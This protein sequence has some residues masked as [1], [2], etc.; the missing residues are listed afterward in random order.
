MSRKKYLI[1][2]ILIFIIFVFIS[3]K[4]IVKF[5]N[6]DT[7]LYIDKGFQDIIFILIALAAILII[8][9]LLYYLPFFFILKNDFVFHFDIDLTPMKNIKIHN[10]KVSSFGYKHKKFIQLRVIRC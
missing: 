10:F 6:I 7:R 5:V 4:Q 2:N 9:L 1:S 8:A 3:I